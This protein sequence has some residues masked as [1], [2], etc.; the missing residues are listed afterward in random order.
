MM[1]SKQLY[2][3]DAERSTIGGLLMDFSYWEGVCEAV[4]EDDFYRPEHRLIFS[5]FRALTDAS[6]PVD[7]VTLIGYLTKSNEIDEVGGTAYLLDIT[8]STPS[9]SNIISYA[10]IVKEF[11]SLRNIALAGSKIYQS[12]TEKDGL[13]VSELISQAEQLVTELSDAND[14]KGGFRDAGEILSVTVDKIDELFNSGNSLSGIGSGIDDL[15]KM[16]NGLQKKD[17]IILAGR[18]SMGKTSLAMNIVEHISMNNSLPALVFS[19]EMPAEQLMMRSISSVGRVD[20]NILR[21]GKLENEHWSKV[22]CAVKALKDSKL[23]IDD[24]SGLS[25]SDVR[26]RAR[27]M[28][29]EHGGVGLIMIDYLQLMRIPNFKENR[30]LEISEISRSLKAIAKEFDCP[31]IALSQLNRSLENRTDKRPINSDLRESG[32]IEQDADVIMFVYRDEVYHEDSPHKGI[33]E[34]IIG[35]QR[36]GPIGTCRAAFLGQYTRFENLAKGYND[37]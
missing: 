29:R 9:V 18:P 25:P 20:Q 12:A 13:N 5:A 8:E 26:S 36:N 6:E 15:D 10:R 17:L 23:K 27:K 1:S 24:T 33:A 22:M 35:K 16:T 3:I 2:S 7:V 11:S 4:S 37:Y 28:A 19:L 31:V 32:A 30:T 21:N 34:I 14:I